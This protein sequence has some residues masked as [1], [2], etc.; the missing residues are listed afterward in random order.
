MA[1]T[2]RRERHSTEVLLHKMERDSEVRHVGRGQ[3]AHPDIKGHPTE[4]VEIGE[5]ARSDKGNG[6]QAI[7]GNKEIGAAESQRKSQRNLNA[8]QTVEIP[9]EIPEPAKP[10]ISE[11]LSRESQH[12][13]DLNGSYGADDFPDIP[14]CL[15]RTLTTSSSCVANGGGR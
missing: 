15:R 9:V 12:L 2:E 6:W 13:N 8:T 7:G 5:K 14:D 11:G 10:L 1:A 3:W 4:S